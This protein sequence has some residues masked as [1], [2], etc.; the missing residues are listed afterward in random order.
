ML[1]REQELPSELKSSTE[2]A[3]PRRAKER[4]LIEL[5]NVLHPITEV[6]RIEPMEAHPITLKP[7]P[8][9]M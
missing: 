9:R 6:F 5:P 1:L 3:E 7:D 4:K 2:S 8:T